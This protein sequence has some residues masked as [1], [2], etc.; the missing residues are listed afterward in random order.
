ML[1]VVIRRIRP[2]KEPRLRAWLAELNS[3]ADEVRETF[4]GETVRAEQA[5]I[6]AGAEGPLLVY[7][8]EAEDFERGSKAYAASHHK[9][10]KEHRAVMRECLAESP[11][12]D[13]L[14]DVSLETKPRGG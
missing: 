13:P 10:D 12:V 7:V 1:R 11:K 8:M 5:Y 6:V 14:Y 3:R 4:R 9:I 2:E